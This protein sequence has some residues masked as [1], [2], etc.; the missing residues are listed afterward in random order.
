MY[1]LC[2]FN[3]TENLKWFGFDQCN[4]EIIFSSSKDAIFDQH[5]MKRF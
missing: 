1:F 2:T 3:N 4:K 5:F